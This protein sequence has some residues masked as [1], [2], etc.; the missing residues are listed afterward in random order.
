MYLSLYFRK[1]DMKIKEI[2][3]FSNLI[4]YHSFRIKFPLIYKIKLLTKGVIKICSFDVG[5]A[6]FKGFEHARAVR[7]QSIRERL[8]IF[9]LEMT[10]ASNSTYFASI[11][12]ASSSSVSFHLASN[13]PVSQVNACEACYL[14]S[15]ISYLLHLHAGFRIRRIRQGSRLNTYF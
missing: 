10:R 13:R 6:R 14:L 5:V 9:L 4:T 15:P 8:R 2:I 3:Q 1:E 12:T 11:E 7:Y